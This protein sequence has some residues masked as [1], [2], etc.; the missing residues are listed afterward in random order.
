MGNVEAINSGPGRQKDPTIP[1]GEFSISTA[2][3]SGKRVDT[4]G[5][6]HR[7]RRLKRAVTQRRSRTLLAMVPPPKPSGLLERFP[8]GDFISSNS[9]VPNL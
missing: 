5:K 2:R 8:M 7:Q 9:S 1:L 3:C 6:D 4:M